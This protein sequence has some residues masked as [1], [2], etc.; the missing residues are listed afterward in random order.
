[1]DT[2]DGEEVVNGTSR[3]ESPYRNQPIDL[4]RIFMG[5]F[6]RLHSWPK[7]DPLGVVVDLGSRGGALN[8]IEKAR[9]VMGDRLGP[10]RLWQELPVG[11][12]I[13]PIFHFL[14]QEMS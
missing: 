11:V 3:A 13:R 9:R 10:V 4:V 6:C 8:A 5:E 7:E 14:Y 1:M 12:F 2:F